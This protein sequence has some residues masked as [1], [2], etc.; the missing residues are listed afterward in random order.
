[1]SKVDAEHNR[2][3]LRK[4]PV[5]IR[6]H[7]TGRPLA[8]RTL[9]RWMSSVIWSSVPRPPTTSCASKDPVA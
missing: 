1:M 5:R 7:R 9:R 6:E 8:G 2:V 4:L 3:V